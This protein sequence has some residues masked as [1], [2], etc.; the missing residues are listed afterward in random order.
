MDET[1]KRLKRICDS[2]V[3]DPYL[4]AVDQG[5]KL[6]TFCNL[7]VYRICRQF[8]SN[9]DFD[10]L[11]A[12]QIF[13]YCATSDKWAK[14]DGPWAAEFAQSGGLAIAAQKEKGHGHCAVVYPAP[15]IRSPSWGKDVPVIANVGK[16]NG[17]MACS[18]GFKTEPSYFVLKLKEA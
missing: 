18:R 9:N 1:P 7:S 10:G 5:D 12:N 6:K 15:M 8:A 16:T 14:V 17:I 2:V 3:A 11:L 13:D 4:V